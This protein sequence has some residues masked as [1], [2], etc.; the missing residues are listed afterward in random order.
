[1]DPYQ[2]NSAS[3]ANSSSSDVDSNTFRVRKRDRLKSLVQTGT[4]A[5]KQE[6]N[7]RYNNYYCAPSSSMTSS[8]SIQSVQAPSIDLPLDHSSISYTENN[9]ENDDSLQRTDTQKAMDE[10]LQ[11]DVASPEMVQPQCLLF[12]TYA[13]QQ[14]NNKQDDII[15][16][17]TVLAGWAFTKPSSTSRL[18]RFLRAAGRTYGGIARNS[19]EDDHFSSL[20]NQFRCQSMKMASIQ[21]TLPGIV[22]SDHHHHFKHTTDVQERKEIT[23]IEFTTV[24]HTG[25]NGR[26]QEPVYLDFESVFNFIHKTQTS[27]LIANA[28]FKNHNGG[29]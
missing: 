26:F 19:V 21:L 27:H 22:N 3:S 13:C 14:I 6:I 25:L 4:S 9:N 12:P 15:R 17:K 11:E 2:S 24:M 7:K 10:I 18:D 20:L 29:L 28:N 8:R 16:Y 23:P 5:I 1:M